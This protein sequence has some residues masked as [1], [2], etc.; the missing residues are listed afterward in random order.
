MPLP[1]VSKQTL[2]SHSAS[3]ARVDINAYLVEQIKVIEREN[4]EIYLYLIAVASADI[5]NETVNPDSDW[6]KE[7]QLRSLIQM[8]MLLRSQAEADDMNK[9]WGDDSINLNV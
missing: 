1:L 4:P 7:A 9:A 3:I 8:Y 5:V 6:M 2:A